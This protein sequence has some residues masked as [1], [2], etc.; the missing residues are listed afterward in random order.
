MRRCVL[1]LM[2][3]LL[4]LQWSWAAVGSVCAHEPDGQH[5]GHHLHQH[6]GEADAH[7]DDEG[8][9]SPAGGAGDGAS[10]GAH[11]DCHSCHGLGLGALGGPT[12]SALG[13]TVNR[14]LFFYRHHLPDPPVEGLLRPPVIPVA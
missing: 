9:E 13:W 3:V 5:F 14:Q 11:P 8:G 6:A 12:E 4:P 1:V 10:L 2:L 7:V